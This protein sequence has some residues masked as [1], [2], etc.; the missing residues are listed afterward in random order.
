MP[1]S[2]LMSS[3]TEITLVCRVPE[4]VGAQTHSTNVTVYVT[5][6]TPETA[7]S[8]ATKIVADL[9]VGVVVAV[10]YLLVV[11]WLFRLDRPAGEDGRRGHGQHGGGGGGH[12][13][14]VNLAP[15][16]PNPERRAELDVRRRVVARED[17]VVPAG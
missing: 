14:L 3:N 5:E 9:V 1:L 17:G 8:V 16:V 6:P 13:G 10:G 7:A 4:T 12:G 15:P 11:Q 2:D